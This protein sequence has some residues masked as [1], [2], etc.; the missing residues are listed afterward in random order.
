M[1]KQIPPILKRRTRSLPPYQ[2]SN[3]ENLVMAQ[4]AE[5]LAPASITTNLAADQ[6]LF[7]NRNLAEKMVTQS[8][9]PSLYPHSVKN[10]MKGPDLPTAPNKAFM[11]TS[12]TEGLIQMDINQKSTQPH[13]RS[14]STRI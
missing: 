1:Q 10:Q 5:K 14:N 2:Q 6:S 12:K 13:P 8:Q 3:K 7:Q 11:H 4:P 9:N